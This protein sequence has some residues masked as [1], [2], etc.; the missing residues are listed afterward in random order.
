MKRYTHESQAP[1][2]IYVSLGGFDVR[3]VET[4]ENQLK[5]KLDAVYYR[6]PFAALIVVGPVLGACFAMAFPVV[7]FYALASGL[8]QRLASPRS[9]IPQARRAGEPVREGVYLGVSHLG[10]RYVSAPDEILQGEPGQRFVRVPT[11]LMLL[12]SPFVGAA[13]VVAFPF[14]A[15]AALV[16]MLAHAV[17]DACRNAWTE[18]AHLA[19][20]RWSP[21]EAYLAP[22]E[23]KTPA[24]Q[25]AALDESLV[26]LNA[27][28]ERRRAAES[29]QTAENAE[30]AESKGAM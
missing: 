10:A 15:A 12:L 1:A 18:H 20:L 14:I 22:T 17:V 5:G 9:L 29:N 3:L 30:S 13:Y 16:G 23:D 8:A 25:P 27:E 26:D 28:I 19:D 6:V 4:G 2:G 7:V 11:A 24:P 21:A